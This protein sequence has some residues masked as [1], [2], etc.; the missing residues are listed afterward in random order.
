MGTWLPGLQTTVDTPGKEGI[1]NQDWREVARVE[2]LALAKAAR[3]PRCRACGLPVL[4]NAGG[5]HWGCLSPS[6]RIAYG[7]KGAPKGVDPLYR[8]DNLDDDV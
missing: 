1:E 7:I 3:A 5:S 6:E 2:A 8:P 4:A